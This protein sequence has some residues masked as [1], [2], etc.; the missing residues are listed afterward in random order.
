M[1]RLLACLAALAVVMAPFAA[2]ADEDPEA[3]RR[4]F[5]KAEK[6]FAL[7]RFDAALA[8][9]EAAFDAKPLPAFLFNIGQCYRNLGNFE[10]AIFSFRKYL[11]LT[12]DAENR[13]SVLDLIADLERQQRAADQQR[14]QEE[15]KKR[16]AVDEERKRREAED[17]TITAP[18][19]PPPRGK[20]LYARWW[21]WTGIGVVA[22]G[23]GAGIYV[24]TRGDDA[25]PSDLGNVVFGR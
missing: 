25:P 5:G 12:P 9:Y 8:E 22:A 4:H 21:F 23:T 18:L 14:A 11:R 7:G 3:A 10:A 17:A 16:R 15:E 24:F 19:A 6:L 20:P 13:Q 2:R 1:P